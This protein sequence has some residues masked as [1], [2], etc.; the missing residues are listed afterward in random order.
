M[1]S[2]QGIN[3]LMEAE[4]EA[5]R[6]ITN[7]RADKKAKMVRAQV[8]AEAEIKKYQQGK[9]SEYEKMKLSKS[10]LDDS[11]QEMLAESE[12]EV[13]GLKQ[14]YAANKDAC[15]KLLGKAV[16]GGKF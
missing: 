7:A 3:K 4:T 10:G 8:E 13:E 14:G 9:E 12:R 16:T 15:V 2:K 1:S 11:G 5:S 6:I